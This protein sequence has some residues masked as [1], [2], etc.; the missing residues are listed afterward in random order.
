MREMHFHELGQGDVFDFGSVVLSEEDIIDFA[1][2]NDP[3][4][5]H[6]DKEVAMQSPFKGLIASGIH[7][8]H[9]FYN[10]EW[11]PRFKNSVYAG[12]GITDWILHRPVYANTRVF[13]IL[14]VAE[15][16]PKPDK[17]YGS[18]VWHFRFT[19]DNE[20]LLQHLDMIVFHKLR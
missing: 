1:R 14:E 8:F 6:L 15:W 2:R 19:D 5:F 18:I 13:C 10:K 3:I 4:P 7:L 16:D 12:K 17:G 20:Q 9:H 11:V